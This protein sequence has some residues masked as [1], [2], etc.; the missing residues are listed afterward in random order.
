MKPTTTSRGVSFATPR[1]DE[2][3]EQASILNL[4]EVLG[5]RACVLGTRRAQFCGVC[6]ART[7]DQGTRQ[8]EGIADLAIYLPPPPIL[9]AT[10]G[11]AW[12]FVWFEVKGR[13]GTLSPAQVEF[14]AI[15]TRAGVNHLV[16]G[17]DAFVEFLQAGGWVR[18]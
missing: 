10:T 12:V 5:G 6:G 15:N 2:K 16:G 11:A 9:A 7:T 3:H 18:A 4:V 17:I 13:G 1:L 8:T 14:R